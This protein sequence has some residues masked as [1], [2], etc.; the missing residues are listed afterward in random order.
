MWACCGQAG[1]A[2]NWLP[3]ACA[4]VQQQQWQARMG[5]GGWAAMRLTSCAFGVQVVHPPA[6]ALHECTQL[7]CAVHVM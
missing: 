1:V 5:L 3:S 7:S 2:T 4:W 6:A